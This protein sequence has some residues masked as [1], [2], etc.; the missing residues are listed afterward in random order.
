MPS[1]YGKFITAIDDFESM[2]QLI[3]KECADFM[4]VSTLIG[5][6]VGVAVTEIAKMTLKAYKSTLP[7]YAKIALKMTKKYATVGFTALGH[8]I[9]HLHK[10]SKYKKGCSKILK[11]GQEYKKL[12]LDLIPESIS[13]LTR[14]IQSYN[15]CLVEIKNE[16]LKTI[17]KED[18]FE[19]KNIL[20]K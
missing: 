15:D 3:I 16:L 2:S 20:E 9:G 18:D 6:E 19:L 7:P 8:G 17:N 5:G 4:R 1:P 14:G 10:K 12:S 11:Q 13:I